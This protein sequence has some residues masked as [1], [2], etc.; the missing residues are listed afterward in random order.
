MNSNQPLKLHL[1]CG[2]IKIPGFIN[3]DSGNENADIKCSFFEL[4]Y[5]ENSVDLIY[6]CHS[7]EHIGL[8]IVPDFLKYLRRLLKSEGQLYISV[9]DFE[10]LSS[11]YLSRK[12]A[13][14]EIVRAI[15]GG[16]EYE[17]NTHFI[18]F[19]YDLLSTLLK[20]AGFS[21]VQ[22]YEPSIFLPD[23]IKDTS[24]YMIKGFPISLNILAYSS[25]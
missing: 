2:N 8:N 21:N 23:G 24:T 6:M 1:G 9:P 13:L 25:I 15:H 10:I 17:G 18:S 20:R 12:V 11:V 7:L 5:R 3:I 14:S 19:D 16:Q 22:R 4:P